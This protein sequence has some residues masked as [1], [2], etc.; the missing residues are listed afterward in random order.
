MPNDTPLKRCSRKDK[1]LHPEGQYLPASTNYFM[2]HKGGF[3]SQCHVCRKEAKRLSHLR[4][5]DRDNARTTKWHEEHQEYYAEYRKQRHL[6]N[7]EPNR[8]RALLWYAENRAY[9]AVRDKIK[10]DA[11]PEKYR[12]ASRR[13]RL[14][15]KEQL[16]LYFRAWRKD[17]RHREQNNQYR[18]NWEKKHPIEC[19]AK[20]AR[21]RARKMLAP[22]AYTVDDVRLLLKS[23]KGLCWWC[24][25]PVD[26][27]HVDH[28]IP[29]SRGGSNA[30]DNLCISCHSCNESKGAKLPSEWGDRLL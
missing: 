22:G 7:P 11:D 30:P 3:Y 19:R 8:L 25:N 29:L 1:C 27:Y 6:E 20:A 5:Q 4:T 24:G 9:V 26:K 28:R 2:P 23:Q 14:A 15:H 18:R 16:R 13:Y 17:A 21:Y 10:Y 12:A